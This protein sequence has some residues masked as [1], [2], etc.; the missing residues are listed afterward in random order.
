MDKYRHIPLG[1]YGAKLVKSDMY[2]AG[3]IDDPDGPDQTVNLR[4]FYE[5]NVRVAYAF[6]S[7]RSLYGFFRKSRIESLKYFHIH[8][9]HHLEAP[10]ATGIG[11][12]VDPRSRGQRLIDNATLRALYR[13]VED[14]DD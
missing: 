10:S 8:P 2:L 6:T 12:L 5:G 11:L 13:L 4:V 14:F 1:E 3:Y 9:P 7:Y